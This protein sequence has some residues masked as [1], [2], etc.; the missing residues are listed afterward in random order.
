MVV[1]EDPADAAR[2][3]VR[4]FWS[5]P[6]NKRLKGETIA[7]AH[8]YGEDSIEGIADLSG[9]DL[10]EVSRLRETLLAAACK[11]TA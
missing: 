2:P 5:V 9:L 1:D 4:T 10:P 3:A 11:D 6:L 8:C 7:L